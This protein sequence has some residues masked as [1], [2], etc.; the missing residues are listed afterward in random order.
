MGK[1][2][3][4]GKVKNVTPTAAAGNGRGGV[5]GAWNPN[6]HAR[7]WQRAGARS[8]GAGFRWGQN[9]RRGVQ[10]QTAGQ[11]FR[12]AYRRRG[13][14]G[15]NPTVSGYFGRVVGGLAAA[16]PAWAARAAWN[17]SK[18][19]GRLSKKVTNKVRGRNASTTPVTSTAVP[20]QSQAG[21]PTTTPRQP[22]PGSTSGQQQ[23][24]VPQPAPQPAFTPPNVPV[25]APAG[26]P[27][28]V[29]AGAGGSTAG[30]TRMQAFPPYVGAVDFYQ[31]ALKWTPGSD[32]GAVWNL[33]AALPLVKESVYLFANGFAK[34]VE[35]CQ[36]DLQGG[37]KPH[38]QSSLTEVWVALK[39]AAS[40]A[41]GLET[42]FNRAYAD[43]IAR[44]N[45]RGGHTTNV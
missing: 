38:M 39:G 8:N 9:V 29:G 26:S 40:A 22:A 37:L 15:H 41:Q 32:S 12:R 16:I 11:A 28:P 33:E 19:A 1:P 23:K 14:H 34:F 30:G 24:P 5:R 13:K 17:T 27:T 25:P 18:R 42:A 2:G 21:T 3:K 36:E 4:T 45:I 35:H 6:A 10:Q 31:L 43:D 20:V 7:G 44:K